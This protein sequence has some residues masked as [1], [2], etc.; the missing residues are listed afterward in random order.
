MVEFP[1][2]GQAIEVILRA[3]TDLPLTITGNMAVWE[4]SENQK[5]S[6][7]YLKRSDNN[8]DHSTIE[9]INDKWYYL[10]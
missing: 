10:T 8:P 9:Y 3:H 6:R 4:N 1:E 7:Y 5:A 2:D